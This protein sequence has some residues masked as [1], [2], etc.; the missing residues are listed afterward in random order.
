MTAL[1]NIQA[2]AGSG[3]TST[4]IRMYVESCNIIGPDKT[5]AITFTRAAADEL[6]E[7][8]ALA[9][10]YTE[11]GS[12]LRR[13]LPFVGTVHSLCLKLSELNPKDLVDSRKLRD[14]DRRLTSY[15]PN[16]EEMETWAQGELP[17][18]T[19]ESEAA[20]W[21]RSAALHR[22]IPFEDA[23]GLIDDEIRARI[24]VG[25]IPR[26]ISQYEDWKKTRKYI[27]FEDLLLLGQ[28]LRPPVRVVLHDESQDA[29]P[30]IWSVVNAW[31]LA[32]EVASFVCV[33]DA[34]QALY[35]W[36]GGDP[37]LFSGRDGDWH[38]L[39][40]SYR[41][42]D[43]SVRYARSILEPVFGDDKRFEQLMQWTGRGLEGCAPDDGSRFWLARTNTLVDFKAGELMDKGIPFRR[44]GKRGPL[45]SDAANGY[46]ALIRQAQ[47]E[48]ISRDDLIAIARAIEDPGAGRY[49]KELPAGYY[50]PGTVQAAFGREPGRVMNELPNADYFLRIKN[51]YGP[52]ALFL[53]PKLA[54]GTVHSAKGKECFET[55]LCTNWA[56]KPFGNL[57]TI[58][59]ARD[60][61]CVFYVASTR[62]RKRLVLES[63][64]T[65]G[66]DGEYP[67]PPLP[68]EYGDA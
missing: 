62:H 45:Q 12:I 25:D 22:M 33:G 43:E 6:R 11:R 7:R 29:S 17:Y 44:L 41:L 14:F 15:V 4:V 55:T 67:Y 65:G 48:P 51:S 13:K 3:K 34:H 5:A 16:M 54:I 46:R 38:T 58:Q 47:G 1:M 56:S 36:A 42:T 60:E 68:E 26:I 63:L 28:R 39:P 2:G 50:G 20:L 31:G 24:D 27:D 37:R 18:K 66:R 59:G 40:Y 21:V 61:C 57:S 10:G 19:N 8:C 35:S 9:L 49:L 53:T 52:D 64:W 23:I 32:P 30:L